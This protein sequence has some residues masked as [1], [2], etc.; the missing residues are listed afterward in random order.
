MEQ[1]A[2]QN[3]NQNIP[4]LGV[5][6]ANPAP[7]SPENSF[8]TTDIPDPEKLRK[9]TACMRAFYVALSLCLVLVGLLAWEIVD[10][11]I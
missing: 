5:P 3:P 2:P 9:A 1:N 6:G 11:V 7:S 4:F 8:V 10:L